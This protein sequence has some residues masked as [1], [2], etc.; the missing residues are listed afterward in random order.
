M[1]K[2]NKKEL[3][4]VSRHEPN[5]GQV[6]LAQ[7]MGY[8]GIK[9]VPVTFTDD[10][11]ADLESAGIHEKTIAVVAPSH[12]TNTLLNKGYTLIEFVNSPVK[13]EKTVFCCEGAYQ[14]QLRSAESD[15]TDYFKY[16]S[17]EAPYIGANFP[18]P[19]FYGIEQEYIE[20]PIPID[21]QY[22]SSLI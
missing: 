7:K 18:A 22:E 8:L 19:L 4:F 3:V 2:N 9:Q 14:F 10:P 20:C 17:Q 5:N 11:I 12:I 13:R 21:E 15:I 1:S 16:H 6:S